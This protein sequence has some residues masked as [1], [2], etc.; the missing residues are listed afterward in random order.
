MHVTD[1]NI[2]RRS[3]IYPRESRDHLVESIRS[4]VCVDRRWKGRRLNHMGGAE[5]PGYRPGAAIC[6]P[7]GE[8]PSELIHPRGLIGGIQSCSFGLA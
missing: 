8:Q 7:Q 4:G 3:V 6:T 2:H 5:D 1:T